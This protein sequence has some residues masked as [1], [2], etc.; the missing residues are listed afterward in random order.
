MSSKLGRHCGRNQP[1]ALDAGRW[2]QV[3]DRLGTDPARRV[4][5]ARRRPGGLTSE[6][7]RAM[8]EQLAGWLA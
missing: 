1:V 4:A 2:E 7:V 6:D 5:S 8:R 3:P